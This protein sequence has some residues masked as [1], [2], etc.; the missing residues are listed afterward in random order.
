MPPPRRPRPSTRSKT[1][2]DT[3]GLPSREQVA[4]FVRE[5]GE[6][7]LSA[8]ASFFGVKGAD[9]RA[10]RHMIQDMTG[11]GETS[12]RGRKGVAL[13]GAFPPVGVAD[14]ESRDVDGELWVRL[15]GAGDDLPAVLLT[16]GRPG[17]DARKGGAP[18]LGDRVLV[19]FEPVGE[20][21]TEAWLIK[22]LG[23]AAPKVLGVVRKAARQVR[24]EPADRRG[25]ES[26]LLAG[27]EASDLR[28]GDLVLVQA[29][30][31]S[32]ERYGLRP[33]RLL[34]IIGREDEPR[35]ASILA[36]AAHDIPTGFPEAA[37]QEAE[38]APAPTLGRR[39]DLRDLPLIT[40]DPAD[41]RDHDDAVFA[42]PDP[43]LNNLG[44]WIVWVA[45]ADVAGYVRPGS[46]LDRTA[47]TKGNSVY[48]PDRVE[49]MLPRA[50]VRR[51]VLPGG[52]RGPGDHGRAAG[53]RQR[54]SQARAPLR[55]AA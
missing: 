37:E 32:Q 5:R 48:F 49:P 21:L 3:P 1:P 28:D 7:D 36:I 33:A 6:T 18:G 55:A 54:G 45:I 10:L 39:T 11:E 2:T 22:K 52:G 4:V 29:D 19:R 30:G 27:P 14:V 41:A 51:P 13:A 8:M 17:E 53:V 20:G 47:W 42:E 23:V 9:R 24:V 34:E 44:G 35:A 40:I 26:F 43:E 16:P 46:A 50:P 15:S 38:A 25:K 31:R 12:R